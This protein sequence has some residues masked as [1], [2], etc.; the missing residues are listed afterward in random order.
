MR[1]RKAK[2]KRAEKREEKRWSETEGKRKIK[3]K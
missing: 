2:R 1:K 3:G